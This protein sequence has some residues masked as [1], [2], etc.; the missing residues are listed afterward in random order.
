MPFSGLH[1]GTNYAFKIKAVSR[2]DS[3]TCIG[4]G[5]NNLFLQT[6]HQTCPFGELVLGSMR[7]YLLPEKR[8]GLKEK[9]HEMNLYDNVETDVL[10]KLL[11]LCEAH[12]P[13]S[14]LRTEKAAPHSS[15]YTEQLIIRD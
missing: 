9:C 14:T 6:D 11:K 8:G 13:K 15:C 1:A 4:V 10:C 7:H 5:I 3:S 12:R 2:N